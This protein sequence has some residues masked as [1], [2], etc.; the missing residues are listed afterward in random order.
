MSIPNTF[1]INQ[2]E[3]M[4]RSLQSWPSSGQR[5][6]KSQIS[7]NQVYDDSILQIPKLQR[8]RKIR[9]NNSLNYEPI[10]SSKESGSQYSHQL[11]QLFEFIGSHPEK[12]IL[13]NEFIEASRTRK[14]RGICR[15]QALNIMKTM[16]LSLF[17]QMQL[18]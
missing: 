18:T 14:I 17:E 7:G 10:N 12:A 6:W 5:T 1:E 3:G 15:K 13:S 16:I 4:S 9:K 11:D 2:S 8:I